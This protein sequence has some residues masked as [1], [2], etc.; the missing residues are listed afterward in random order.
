[1]RSIADQIVLPVPSLHGMLRNKRWRLSRELPL[2]LGL[3]PRM[4]QG[5]HVLF[6]RCVFTSQS[7][8]ARVPRKPKFL[9]LHDLGKI[10]PVHFV[11]AHQG[12]FVILGFVAD[13][14]LLPFVLVHVEGSPVKITPNNTSFSILTGGFV[15]TQGHIF[16]HQFLFCH[17]ETPLMILSFFFLC[18]KYIHMLQQTL[19]LPNFPKVSLLLH[20]V[21]VIRV[22][23]HITTHFVIRIVAVVLR[24]VGGCRCRHHHHGTGFHAPFLYFLR[25]LQLFLVFLFLL[26]MLVK[27][28]MAFVFWD[29]H[30]LR[31]HFLVVLRRGRVLFTAATSSTTRRRRFLSTTGRRIRHV[32]VCLGAWAGWFGATLWLENA[33]DD[34]LLVV[35]RRRHHHRGFFSFSPFCQ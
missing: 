9:H 13:I 28:C 21:I 17:V 26:F 15:S 33:R 4:D 12:S 5:K 31:H 27:D 19:Q 18:L 7:L 14:P 20:I 22:V 1:M 6:G 23:G 16:F 24:R 30:G 3:T 10:P 11:F 2:L 29:K 32:S 25:S 34:L 35:C 8:V